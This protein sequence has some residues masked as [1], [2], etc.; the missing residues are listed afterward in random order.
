MRV[1]PAVLALVPGVPLLVLACAGWAG[2][3]HFAGLLAEGKDASLAEVLRGARAHWLTATGL[4]ACSGVLLVGLGF[5]LWFYMTKEIFGP[6]ARMLLAGLSF[7]VTVFFVGGQAFLIPL[8]VWRGYGFSATVRKAALLTLDN[9]GLAFFCAV[10]FAIYGWCALW[11]RL[12]A[13]PLLAGPL[14]MFLAVTIRVLGEKYGEKTLPEDG[15]RG[16]RDLIR[17]WDMRD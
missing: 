3:L 1:H 4:A 13:V 12:L 9:P 11:T 15:K 17:P 7:W 5:N 8:A 10:V 6:V 16:L 14:A 2:L